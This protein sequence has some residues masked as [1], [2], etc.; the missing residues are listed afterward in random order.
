LSN[1]PDHQTFGTTRRGKR[2]PS[3]LMFRFFVRA[4]V[5]HLSLEMPVFLRTSFS[6]RLQ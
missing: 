3:C 1:F 2:L 4:Q 5:S 6:T